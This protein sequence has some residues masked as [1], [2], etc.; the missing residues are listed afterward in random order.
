[1]EKKSNIRHF[2]FKN[3]NELVANQNPHARMWGRKRTHLTA[4][5][6]REFAEATK[7]ARFMALIPYVSR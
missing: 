5:E 4:K 1:M 3:V 7:R 2:D 6:Q